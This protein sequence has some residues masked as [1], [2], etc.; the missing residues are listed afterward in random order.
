MKKKLVSIILV[1]CLA[2]G[3]LAGCGKGSADA[4]SDTAASDETQTSD[5][6]ETAD[7]G[8][9]ADAKTD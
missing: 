2:I 8:E 9:T 5:A 3:S 6:E 1:M 4:T 7:A